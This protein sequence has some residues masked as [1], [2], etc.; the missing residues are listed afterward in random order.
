MNVYIKIEDKG[1]ESEFRY[2]SYN[3]LYKDLE[4][5]FKNGKGLERNDFLKT[6]LYNFEKELNK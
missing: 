1:K 2:I 3:G 5:A 6:E 4:H